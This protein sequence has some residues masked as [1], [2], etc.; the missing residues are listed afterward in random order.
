MLL[1][2]GI[3]P[4]FLG[5]RVSR[6]VRVLRSASEILTRVSEGAMTSVIIA[7]LAAS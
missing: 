6:L 2:S 5:G 3:V 7:F 1:Q 4:C